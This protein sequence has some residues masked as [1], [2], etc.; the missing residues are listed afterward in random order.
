MQF[1]LIICNVLSAASSKHGIC[2]KF[3]QKVPETNEWQR[4]NFKSSS[5]VRHF[6]HHR[7]RRISFF[8]LQ[9]EIHLR[10]R[11][12][13]FARDKYRYSHHSHW[14]TTLQQIERDIRWVFAHKNVRINLPF[15]QIYSLQKFHSAGSLL[16]N[17]RFSLCPFCQPF[18]CPRLETMQFQSVTMARTL[19][20]ML[21][22]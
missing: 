16:F 10:R 9:G 19:K 21:Y 18:V 12:N 3:H 4:C 22:I 15:S 8:S 14:T 13:E 20:V 5:V 6:G 1:K 17:I 2:K 7:Q 11:S